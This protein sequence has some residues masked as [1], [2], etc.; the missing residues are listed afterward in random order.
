[1][2]R[3]DGVDDDAALRRDDRHVRRHGEVEAEVHLLVDLLAL[4]DVGARVGELRL[5]LRVAELLERVL[6]HQLRRALLR[7]VHQVLIVL[8]AQVAVDLQ[9]AREHVVGRDLLVRRVAGDRRHDALQERVV[10]L[11]SA[12]AVRLRKHLVVE[13][14]RR[15]RCPPRRARRPGS[16]SRGP[17]RRA[18]RRTRRAAR[19]RCVMPAPVAG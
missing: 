1:M 18:A 13:R 17:D 5:D 8:P 12:L 6:E 4:V 11:D 2:P 3:S 14:A 15:P 9:E 7:E 19:D 10:E 16:A